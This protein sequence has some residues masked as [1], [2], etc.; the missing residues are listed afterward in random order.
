[1][2]RVHLSEPTGE[3]AAG[4]GRFCMG[5]GWRE[6]RNDAEFEQVLELCSDGQFPRETALTYRSLGQ[7]HQ[8]RGELRRIGGGSKAL[9]WS[10]RSGICQG[11]WIG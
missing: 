1:M 9:I 5:A 8:A 4:A 6:P 2:P 10:R 11:C 3:K 7:M